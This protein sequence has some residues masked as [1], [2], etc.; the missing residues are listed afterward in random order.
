[1]KRL[2][3]GEAAS[4]PTRRPGR[5]RRPLPSLLL[6]AAVAVA[7]SRAPG[8]EATLA[9]RGGN[10]NSAS[11]Y[12]P[13]LGPPPGPLLA[14]QAD[15]AE[16]KARRL[17]ALIALQKEAMQQQQQALEGLVAQQTD[18][19]A[20]EADLKHEMQRLT[21]ADAS[22]PIPAE[23]E[24]A[25]AFAKATVGYGLAL[26][27]ALQGEPLPTGLPVIEVAQEGIWVETLVAGA[28]YV[29]FMMIAAYLYGV[30]FTYAYPE[31]RLQPA[32]VSRDDF[33]FSLVD[34][35]RCDPDWRI[36][37]CSWFCA[38]IRWADTAG[39]PKIRFLHFW[40][41]LILF[42]VLQVL[43]GLTVVFCL[44]LLAMCVVS[45][46]RIRQVYGLPSGNCETCT[47]DCLVWLFC[48]PCAIMQEAL[49]IEFIDAYDEY[50]AGANPGIPMKESPAAYPA[51]VAAA[52]GGSPEPQQQMFH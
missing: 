12:A 29:L 15:Q 1:M 32:R 44:L 8:A 52:Q 11:F 21:F 9:L 47:K 17:E 28:G 24:Q 43:T 30:C 23:H 13:P 34:G 3:A 22:L 37:C 46:Q 49:Q 6:A 26:K 48:T 25:G 7:A 4:L 16:T 2:R 45:R 40:Q 38:P 51:A 27:E 33:T 19:A 50:M 41:A 36:C 14:G 18:L 35:C 31:L 20:Q 10:A 39:S 5:R 42:T